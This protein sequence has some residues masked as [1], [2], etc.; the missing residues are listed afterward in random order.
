MN[1]SKR[2]SDEVLR[3]RYLLKD[4]Q[5]KSIET[6]DQM[7]WRVANCVASVESRY[8]TSDQVLSML[9]E[10]FYKMMAEGKFLPNSPTLMNAGRPDSLLSACCVL[11]IN[12]SI[13]EI[14]DAIKN[15]AL[16]QKAGGGTGFAF[17]RLRPTGDIVSSS[18]GETSGP[19]S[20]WKVF[21]R[22]ASLSDVIRAGGNIRSS[23][24]RSGDSDIAS[25]GAG[26]TDLSS[27]FSS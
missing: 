7:Y 18:G 3:K 16:I 19:I 1:I 14:F 12:D 2:L 4:G 27:S 9:P 10:I 15:T 20:F 8:N 24:F 17:D 5:G 22:V 13:P 25:G 26:G 11:P 21:S 23:F 6:V